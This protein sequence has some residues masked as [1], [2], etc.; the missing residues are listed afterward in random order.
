MINYSI[1]MRSVNAKLNDDHQLI[2]HSRKVKNEGKQKKNNQIF[3]R[4]PFFYYLC[5]KFKNIT[6]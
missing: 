1:V 6:I 5:L 3:A 2:F 4:F